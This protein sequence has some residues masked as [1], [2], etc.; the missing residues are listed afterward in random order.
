MLPCEWIRFQI[1]NL[2]YYSTAPD[3]IWEADKGDG[4][5]R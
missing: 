4:T 1:S 3:K 5:D 2:V